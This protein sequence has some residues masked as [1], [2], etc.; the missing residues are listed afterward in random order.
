MSCE[1]ERR[2]DGT[3]WHSILIICSIPHFLL[4]TQGGWNPAAL[5]ATAAGVLPSLPGFLSARGAWPLAV[6]GPLPPALAAVYDG[7]WFVG[8]FVSS[9]TY[10]AL[11]GQQQQQGEMQPGFT[12]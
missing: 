11:M 1:L 6:L 12:G 10:V 9:L 3:L 8:V 4:F 2:A 7:A 5:A